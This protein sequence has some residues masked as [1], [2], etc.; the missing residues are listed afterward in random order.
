[1]STQLI[2]YPQNYQGYFSSIGFA[3]QEFIIDGANFFSLNQSSLGTGTVIGWSGTVNQVLTAQSGSLAGITTNTWYRFR[4]T[5]G[6]ITSTTPVETSNNLVLNNNGSSTGV[7]GVYQKVSNLMQGASY[8]VSVDQTNVTATLSYLMIAV[9]SPSDLQNPSG[10]NFTP[11]TTTPN[12][13]T[14]T[15]SSTEQIIVIFLLNLP[16][17]N[18][19]TVTI[20]NISVESLQLPPSQIGADLQNG[21]VICDLYQEEDI[22]LT[23]SIDDFKNIAEQ[24]QS[25]SKDFDLPATKR[26]NRIFNNMFEVTRASDGIIFNP[27]LK[28]KCVLKQDGFILFEGYLRLINVKDK[29]GEISYNVNLYSEV[30][31]LADVLKER[32]F[33]DLNFSELQHLYNKDSI[34]QSWTGSLPLSNP[35]GANS[36]AGATGATT[37]NVLKYPFIDWNHQFIVGGTNPN[38]NATVGNP[39]LPNLQTAFRPCIKLKYIL[40]NIFAATDF[41]YT[42]EFLEGLMFENLYMDFNWDSTNFVRSERT[43]GVYIDQSAPINISHTAWQNIVLETPANSP[44]VSTPFASDLGYNYTD[45]RF[46]AAYDNTSYN[47][48]VFCEMSAT[49]APPAGYIKFRI[50]H[51]DSSGNVLN[52]FNEFTI[53]PQSSSDPL[54]YT[55]SRTVLLQ[56][57]DR[58]QVQAIVENINTFSQKSSSAF[59]TATTTIAASTG[60]ISATTNS[61]LQSLR[62]ELN[63]W[64]FIKGIMTMFNL[65]SMVDEDDADNIL[66]EPYSEIFNTNTTGGLSLDS[67][68]DSKVHDWTDKVDASEMELKPLTDINKKTTFKFVEDDDDFMFNTFKRIEN[69]RLFGSRVW[70]PL[71]FDILEGEKEVVATPFAATVCKALESAYP[72]LVV[73]SLYSKDEEGALSGFDNSPRIFYNNG[74]KAT[75]ATYYIPSQN[76]LS[77]EN[78]PEFLQFSHLSTIP[79]VSFSTI[80]FHFESQQLESN[81]GVAPIDNLFNTYWLPYMNDLYNADTRI[82]TLKVNL[83][84]SDVSEFKFYDTVMIKNRVFRVNKIE[85]K[86]NSLATV[87]FILIP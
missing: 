44:L 83:M 64:E 8:K 6:A 52:V 15:A 58:L 68:F 40:D 85:Y 71:G 35:L 11:L 84:P 45:N 4:S 77:S 86:P 5:W 21:Q 34:K 60:G 72:Y 73:P 1:M 87:E 13:L 54:L 18:P 49:I 24:V 20:S 32:T 17:Y 57:G 59:N 2:L 23:L 28:S 36:F 27:Y 81:V 31:A 38:T 25:Y 19:G 63:Q 43:L 75:G 66:I 50:M 26:N 16:P 53:T 29:E 55:T 22:P 12:E 39:E 70:E 30:I 42:S 56:Q 80:D 62:G 41:R 47:L 61:L 76:N 37:T 7:S 46:V 33:S 67:R 65:V 10:I 51:D 78:Q 9:Y 79:S 14:F 48:D 3:G 74:V 69:G 82:M